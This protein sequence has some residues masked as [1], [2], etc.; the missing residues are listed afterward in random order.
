MAPISAQA[1]STALTAGHNFFLQ[2]KTN[3]ELQML[4]RSLFDCQSL[5]LN[6]MSGAGWQ[7]L[8]GSTGGTCRKV[9]TRT[10]ISLFG[11]R[12]L[13]LPSLRSPV[14][15]AQA[16]LLLL[17]EEVASLCS[18]FLSMT[19]RDHLASLCQLQPE[20][21]HQGGQ[22]LGR[23]GVHLGL[24]HRQ[25]FDGSPVFWKRREDLEWTT[26]VSPLRAF[27]PYAVH[28]PPPVLSFFPLTLF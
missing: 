23:A 3:Q 5:R 18:I 27:P 20:L 6:V 1:K 28:L 10:K 17:R 12:A 21:V 4:S 11:G 13:H 14:E 15:E 9:W 24:F 8:H 25:S 19:S 16:G 26:H 2:H 22:L 7:K